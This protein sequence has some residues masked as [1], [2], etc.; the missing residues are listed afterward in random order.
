MPQK[1]AIH[2]RL[3]AVYRIWPTATATIETTTD[4]NPPKKGRQV[5]QHLERPL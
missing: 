2:S 3:N 5:L 4:N 1:T